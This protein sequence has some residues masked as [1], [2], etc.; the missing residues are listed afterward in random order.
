MLTSAPHTLRVAVTDIGMVG[1]AEHTEAAGIL[2]AYLAQLA[3][4][5]PRHWSALRRELKIRYFPKGASV[6]KQG[7]HCHEV[8]F[9]I[10]GLA[11]SYTVTEKGR[12]FTWA[13]HFNAPDAN[14]K[15]L[16]VTDYAGVISRSRQD[17][18]VETLTA[19]TTIAIPV[20]EVRRLFGHSPAWQNV[21]RR[22]AE[23]AYVLTHRRALSLLT[24]SATERYQEFVSENPR[25]IALLPEFQVAAYVGI[26]PQ[27]LS[28]IKRGGDYQT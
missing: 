14:L 1:T 9:V 15:N 24:K 8:E 5:D 11:R 23:E 16:F 26:T 19:M 17:F 6:L 2:E 7:D 21:G 3:P 12:E 20:S 13:F 28:R 25:L 22:I 10:D 27:S 4:M 18:N